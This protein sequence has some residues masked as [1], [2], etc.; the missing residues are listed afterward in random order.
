M[1]LF[2]KFFFLLS[3]VF[4]KQAFAADDEVLS[5]LK[6]LP[7]VVVT[8]KTNTEETAAGLRHFELYISQPTD[9]FDSKSP[10]FQQK[11]ILFHKNFSEPM[12]LQTSGYSIFGEKLTRIAKKFGTNQ[13]QVEHRYFGKSVPQVLD[14][15]KL[16]VRQSAEDFHLITDRKSVV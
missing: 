16:T 11:L 6:E 4:L 15:S 13:L 10:I 12:L 9:H 14:W 5:K 7:G 8:E 2:Y 3:L 1:L